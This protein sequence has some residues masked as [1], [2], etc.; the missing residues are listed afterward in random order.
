MVSLH[1]FLSVIDDNCA[2][3]RGALIALFFFILILSFTMWFVSLVID[4]QLGTSSYMS[5]SLPNSELW[6]AF[7]SCLKFFGSWFTKWCYFFKTIQSLFR[8]A[9]YLVATFLFVN[10]LQS[11]VFT[12]VSANKVRIYFFLAYLLFNLLISICN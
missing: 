10:K 1:L 9:E 8:T 5:P 6:V 4:V 7:S 2:T 3:S 11:V 12:L